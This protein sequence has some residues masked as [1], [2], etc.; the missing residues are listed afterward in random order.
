MKF[1]KKIGI[2]TAAV[3]ML[4]IIGFSNSS[5]AMPPPPE[6]DVYYPTSYSLSWPSV[7][8]G[9]SLTSVRHYDGS[10]MAIRAGWYWFFGVHFAINLYYYFPNVPAEVLLF[11][12]TDNCDTAT[13]QIHITYSDGTHDFYPLSGSGSD[14]YWQVNLDPGKLLYRVYVAFT[15]HNLLGGD[16]YLYVDVCTGI[17]YN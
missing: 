14:G 9:G 11:G 16:R 1:N 15:Y 10:S 12:F 7:L 2:L 17:T 4:F 3:V 6:P 5:Y 13:T 8:V